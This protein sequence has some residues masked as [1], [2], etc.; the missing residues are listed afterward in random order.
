[1]WREISYPN[2]SDTIQMSAFLIVQ[3]RLDSGMN[4]IA[5]K[6]PRYWCRKEDSG[7]QSTLIQ[8]TITLV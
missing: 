4:M 5:G 3:V 6:R 8:S 7:E 2:V 1:M